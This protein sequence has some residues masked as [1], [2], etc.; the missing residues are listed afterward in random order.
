MTKKREEKKYLN[1]Y[2][3]G[4]FVGK[5]EEQT[6]II[7]NLVASV[8]PIDKLTLVNAFDEIVLTT[9]GYFLDSVPDKIWLQE[10]S[11]FLVPMQMGEDDLFPVIYKK[12]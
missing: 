1:V 9:I 2:K 11:T 8:S 4:V 6:K 3:N 7:A 12:I 5:I 10:L